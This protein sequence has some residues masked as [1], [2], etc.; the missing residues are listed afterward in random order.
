MYWDVPVHTK[1]L[2]FMFHVHNC[3]TPWHRYVNECSCTLETA[4]HF[5]ITIASLDL[6]YSDQVVIIHVFISFII[7]SG[8]EELNRV[9]PEAFLPFFI[10]TV[11]HFSK[12]IVRKG[13]DQQCE[14]QRTNFCKAIESKSTRRFV[15]KFVQTQ[16]FDLFVQEMEQ[17]PASQD[18]TGETRT[19]W[20]NIKMYILKYIFTLNLQTNVETTKIHFMNLFIKASITNSEIVFNLM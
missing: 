13:K 9:V 6:V 11:G 8:L 12:Y 4:Y 20:F 10:K 7:T 1:L 3:K 17:R 16:M 18:G 15:K 19:L 5:L 14:F 2:S